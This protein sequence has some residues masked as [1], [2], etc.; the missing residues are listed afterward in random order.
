MATQQSV[1]SKATKQITV[2]GLTIGMT[3]S[4]ALGVAFLGLLSKG[5]GDVTLPPI[6][7]PELSMGRIAAAT[8]YVGELHQMILDAQATGCI[9]RKA[10]S[11][12][13]MNI[14]QTEDFKTGVQYQTFT[15]QS[16]TGSQIHVHLAHQD[17]F[18]VVPGASYNLSGIALD[19]NNILV[20]SFGGAQTSIALDETKNVPYKEPVIGDQKFAVL[21]TYY[22]DAPQP[23]ISTSTIES[24]LDDTNN[25]Y[26]EN[27]YAKM[28]FVG[29]E[30][31][32]QP[33]DMFGWA[34]A[35]ATNCGTTSHVTLL[36]A[37][38]A[39][40]D[41]QVDFTQY[42]RILIVHPHTC[43]SESEVGK[44]LHETP[45]G[46]ATFSASWIGVYSDWVDQ[47]YTRFGV[48][49]ELGHA[50]GLKHAHAYACNINTVPILECTQGFNGQPY[51]EYEDYYD[52]MGYYISHNNAKYKDWLGWL[53]SSNVQTV[54]ENGT[55]VLEP[56]ETA[57]SGLKVLIIPR[58]G[59]QR[60]YV[61]YREDIGWDQ[62]GV[63]H[64]F[65]TGNTPMGALLHV[66]FTW[67]VIEF[68]KSMIFDPGGSATGYELH[69]ALEKDEVFIDPVSGTKITTLDV[70]RDE[71]NPANSRLTVQ[72]EFQSCSDGTL[73]GQCQGTSLYYCDEGALVKDCSKCGSCPSGR[74]CD[75]S[76]GQCLCA[77]NCYAH[78]DDP[79]CP[80]VEDR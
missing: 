73:Y 44:R 66:D 49:H 31:P 69:P 20:D 13:V 75:S 61:E 39:A 4:F 77:V 56:I 30:H 58:T 71:E 47:G 35:N 24:L 12:G 74:V 36:N 50:L 7:C 5:L 68:S 80:D 37:A 63:P 38:M 62:N 42:D 1:L 67:N 52:T 15:Q 76:T 40:F 46:D 28:R 34:Q 60:L 10:T 78:P 72:V 70:V 14:V 25:F 2:I 29:V 59:N 22:N 23:D 27:S 79:C 33:Y 55:F 3:A 6:N 9:V 64:G 16:D 57:T 26:Q 41:L 45:D 18:D 54:T 17:F 53:D 43:R 51:N 48:M 19:A 21:L 65:V 8:D 11:Q 32:D